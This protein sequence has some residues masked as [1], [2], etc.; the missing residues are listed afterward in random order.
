MGPGL[1]RMNVP[2]WEAGGVLAEQ[3]KRTFPRKTGFKIEIRAVADSQGRAVAERLLASL[4]LGG[5]NAE[6]VEGPAP[7]R[8]DILIETSHEMAGLA[9]TLQS[10]FISARIPVQLLVQKK[11][12]PKVIVLHVGSLA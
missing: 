1:N 4:R 9:L 8:E 12:K 11:P 7:P 10:A 3:I 2:Q 6:L 5:L